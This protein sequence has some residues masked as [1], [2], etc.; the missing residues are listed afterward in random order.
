MRNVFDG[1]AKDR[2]LWDVDHALLLFRVHIIF[3]LFLPPFQP[4]LVFDGIKF[5][6]GE[7]IFLL[8]VLLKNSR[9]S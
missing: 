9:S 2:V 1:G 8:V 4:H 5:T 6:N 3:K 7:N